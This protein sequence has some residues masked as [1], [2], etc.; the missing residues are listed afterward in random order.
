MWGLA[1]FS[2]SNFLSILNQS[3]L[4]KLDIVERFFSCSLVTSYYWRVSN[5]VFSQIELTPVVLAGWL[6]PS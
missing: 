6:F 1:I 4:I 2:A 3:A 5:K